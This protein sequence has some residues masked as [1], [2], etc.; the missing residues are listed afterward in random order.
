[1]KRRSAALF[2]VVTA[3]AL[4][5]AA[6]AHSADKKKARKPPEPVTSSISAI[7]G[8]TVDITTGSTTKSLKVTQFTEVRL[9]GQKGSAADLKPGMVVTE[10]VLGA[11]PSV[12]SRINASG[13]AAAIEAPA[14]EKKKKKSTKKKKK[15]TEDE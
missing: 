4:L 11:D 13:S 1:M 14:P 8:N 7:S 10:V 9:N 15:E 3:V 6:P 5:L 2:I 12:A